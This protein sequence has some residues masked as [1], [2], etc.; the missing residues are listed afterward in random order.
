MAPEE[1][2]KALR[3]RPF[4]PL[5]IALTDGRVF[6]VR[7]PELVL[8]G[9]RSAIIGIPAP[10]ETEALYDDRITIDLLHIVSLEPLRIT[11]DG[12]S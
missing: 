5:R 6:E 2:L 8:P 4:W 1:L 9:R 10:G 12:H 11:P 3:E 7:H